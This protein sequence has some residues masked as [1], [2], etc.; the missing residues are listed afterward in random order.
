MW[1]RITK[2]KHKHPKEKH[3]IHK[4]KP[5]A[6]E[7]ETPMETMPEESETPLDRPITT[8]TPF[9]EG[10]DFQ[11]APFPPKQKSKPLPSSQ[12][13]PEPPKSKA[14][15]FDPS[16]PDVLIPPMS[17]SEEKPDIPSNELPIPEEK[18]EPEEPVE[19]PENPKEPVVKPTEPMPSIEE[20][21]AQSVKP[22]PINPTGVKPPLHDRCH[23][24]IKTLPSGRQIWQSNSDSCDQCI[25][26]RDAFNE[27][28]NKL[29]PM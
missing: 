20:P 16:A 12:I 17:L 25:R 27:A 15:I 19:I 29:F 10:P 11:D 14:P 9:M 6:D 21:P 24:T 13:E 23:C 7:M 22:E 8:D 3:H 4:I 5:F 18:E 1:Y 28:Q 26:T 2:L